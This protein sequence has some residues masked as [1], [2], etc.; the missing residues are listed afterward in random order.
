ML[1]DFKEIRRDGEDWESFARDFL[2][3]LG[4]SVDTPPDR[5]A[6]GGK[7]ILLLEQLEGRLNN[8]PFRW[9]VSCKHNAHSGKS[10]NEQDEPNIVERVK[11]FRAEGFLGFYST[12]PSTGL[13]N[14]L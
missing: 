11:S 5:G 4:F 8:Y 3:E 1:I 10:V 6:D 7:D 2:V 12:L 9:L 14:R 13:S